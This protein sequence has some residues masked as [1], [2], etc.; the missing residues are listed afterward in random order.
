[1]RC[2]KC[3]KAYQA[4][5]S[6]EYR[7]PYCGH[8]PN[9]WQ[10][11]WGR[12][13]RRVVVPWTIVTLVLPLFAILTGQVI[14]VGMLLSFILGG[15]MLL[16][17]IKSSFSNLGS[18]GWARGI[19]VTFG[20]VFLIAGMGLLIWL[21]NGA[22]VP[23]WGQMRPIFSGVEWIGI[24]IVAIFGLFAHFVK[25]GM[26]GIL[27]K[28]LQKEPPETQVFFIPPFFT[29]ALLMCILLLLPLELLL[30]LAW[31]NS[32]GTGVEAGLG[33]GVPLIMLP[34][35]LFAVLMVRHNF[36]A[37]VIDSRRL[38]RYYLVGKKTLALRELR[39]IKV[40]TF[41]LPPALVVRGDK[42]SIRFPRAVQGYPT[43]LKLIQTYT[44]LSIH[45]Q[46]E[47]SSPSQDRG[48]HLPYKFEIPKWRM[49]LEF[50]AMILLILIYFALASSGL[51]VLLLQGSVPPFAKDDVLTI[52][53]I[54][55]LVSLIFIPVLILGARQ[56]FGRH[57][58][59]QIAL[60]GEAV[61]IHY[62]FGR[63]ECFPVGC[64]EKVWLQPVPVRVRAKYGG[65]FVRSSTTTYDLRLRLTDGRE[66]KFNAFRLSLFGLTPEALLEVFNDHYSL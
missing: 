17:G 56:S 60:T 45:K 6:E 39:R 30:P 54:F 35:L 13:S 57:H 5:P 65:A 19:M 11:W 29:G 36:G 4:D 27:S 43:L 33:L 42:K 37:V 18:P 26:D 7:C 58:P 14:I 51:W 25:K 52:A 64:L 15:Y 63:E 46:P 28:R 62:R 1:M 20:S 21:F 9:P 10:R 34:I 66:I 8:V 16:S 32:R 40:K 41:G 47:R 22:P 48:T 61:H 44:G 50:V 53:I 12:K 49:I 31:L 3:K 38:T 59:I 23:G 24:V 2:P 55:G